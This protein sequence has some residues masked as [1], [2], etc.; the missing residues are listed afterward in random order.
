MSFFMMMFLS[1]YLQWNWKFGPGGFHHPVP[2]RREAESGPKKTARPA[3]KSSGS[4]R[5][6]DQQRNT[7]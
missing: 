3:G 5:L 6:T 2:C 7:P 4:D 1:G